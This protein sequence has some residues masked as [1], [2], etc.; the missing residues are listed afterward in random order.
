MF[1]PLFCFRFSPIPVQRTGVETLGCQGSKRENAWVSRKQ[2][3][4][5]LGVKEASERTLGRQ[6]SKRE[7]VTPKAAAVHVRNGR[8]RVN[9][10]RRP[11]RATNLPPP[12]PPRPPPPPPQAT[13]SSPLPHSAIHPHP[14]HPFHTPKCPTSQKV[15]VQCCST[16]TET[17]TGNDCWG[18]GAEDGHSDFHHGTI[19]TYLRIGPVLS[20]SS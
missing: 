4:E 1:V 10:V 16:S 9:Q 8:Q 19:S 17:I 5:R 20:H 2:A 3:R 7:N 12:P 14:P 18:R 13:P 11:S 15:Q 6:G